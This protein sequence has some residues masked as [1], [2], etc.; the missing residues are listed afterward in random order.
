MYIYIYI[1]IHIYDVFY[2]RFGLYHYST[3]D[4]DYIFFHQIYIQICMIN[5]LL[6]FLF[7]YSFNQIKNM[8]IQIFCFLWSTYLSDK[9]Y[10]SDKSL[11]VLQRPTHLSNLTANI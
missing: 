4:L 1:Y 2:T 9:S 11:R 3:F 7:I 10:I 8:Y 6:N 5:V